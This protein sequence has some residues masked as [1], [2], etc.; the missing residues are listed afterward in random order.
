ML[1]GDDLKPEHT[2][3]IELKKFEIG[4][5]KGLAFDVTGNRKIIGLGI[6]KDIY[7]NEI[8]GI[9]A[10]LYCTKDVRN[11]FRWENG[12]MPK[13]KVGVSLQWKLGR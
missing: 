4:A 6:S 2:V 3:T 5:I 11:L 12:A 1:I 8:F 10:G 7:K 13:L 9:D